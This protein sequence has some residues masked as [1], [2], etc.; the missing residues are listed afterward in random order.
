VSFTET[1]PDA[2]KRWVC[3]RCRDQLTEA[4]VRWFGQVDRGVR[5][6]REAA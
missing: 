3:A 1:S 5:R 6:F 4:V 2:A